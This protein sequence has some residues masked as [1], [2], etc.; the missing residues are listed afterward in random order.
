[1]FCPIV[2]GIIM[3]ILYLIVSKNHR[4]VKNKIIGLA[5]VII[6]LVTS[7]TVLKLA[8]M[9]KDLNSVELVLKGTLLR[10]ETE[11]QTVFD[12]EG[13]PS[14]YDQDIAVVEHDKIQYRYQVKNSTDFF[15]K[16]L[17]IQGEKASIYKKGDH[18]IIV[19]EELNDEQKS[20][21]IN[22]YGMSQVYYWN[23]LWIGICFCIS[24]FYLISKNLD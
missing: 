4:V 21:I 15:T 24:L 23:F 19:N 7:F 12:G 5:G 1:M 6:C 18:Y 16:K 22:Q 2:M 9:E 13:Y 8:H 11:P 20:I 14:E 17:F 10:V 3:L